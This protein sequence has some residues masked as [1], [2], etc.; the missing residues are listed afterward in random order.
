MPDAEV[1]FRA[2]EWLDAKASRQPVVYIS[3]NDIYSLHSAIVESLDV[4][5]SPALN[6]AHSPS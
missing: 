1:H 2:D 6:A 3:P 5:V 4:V